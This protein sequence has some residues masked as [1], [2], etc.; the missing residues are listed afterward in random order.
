MPAE[1]IHG[2]DLSLCDICTP[3]PVAE[4]PPKLAKVRAPRAKLARTSATKSA[5]TKAPGA[6]RPVVTN[7]EQRVYHLT[8]LGNLD[9]IL[10]SGRLL[11]PSAG[12]QPSVD[13][14][15]AEN[16]EER[17][18]VSIGDESVADFVPFFVSPD[19]LLWQGI[20]TSSPDPRLSPAVRTMA[21]AEFVVLVTTVGK[22]GTENSVV[23]VGDAADTQTRFGQTPEQVSR[24][25]GRMRGDEEV[26]ERAEFL[27]RESLPFESVTLI[28]VANNRARDEVRS[29]LS[30]HNLTTKVSI[31][32]P[33]FARE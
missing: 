7:V 19:S 11:A 9:G 2:L 27:V 23:A 32:P 21:P 18:S 16:R 8:P 1:C 25:L 17:Q 4:A 6:V 26:S 5:A 13:I 31:H 29:V 30:A 3:K 14:S 33:W 10:A 12:A 20:R 15:S 28:G 22:A 24:E